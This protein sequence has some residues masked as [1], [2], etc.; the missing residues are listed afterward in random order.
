[1][2]F[3]ELENNISVEPNDTQKGWSRLCSNFCIIMHIFGKKEIGDSH[4]ETGGR[5]SVKHKQQLIT[6]KYV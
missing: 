1:M 3:I 6:E 4:G 2:I 5:A